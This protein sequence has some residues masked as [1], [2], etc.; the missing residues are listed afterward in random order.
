MK[1]PVND[2]QQEQRGDQDVVDEIGKEGPDLDRREQRKQH[3]F[4]QHGREKE[5]PK[6][7]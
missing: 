3:G 6:P 5:S 7:S 2:L 4:D 1:A